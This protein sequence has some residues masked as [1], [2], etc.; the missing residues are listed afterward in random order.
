MGL[1]LIIYLQLGGG[2]SE[3][4]PSSP[5]YGLVGVVSQNGLELLW[6]V[7]PSFH[8]PLTSVIVGEGKIK[9]SMSSQKVDQL[10][11]DPEAGRLFFILRSEAKSTHGLGLHPLI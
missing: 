7:E 1:S 3:P 5:G 4:G 11:L 9:K 2:S 6:F 8:N 10:L